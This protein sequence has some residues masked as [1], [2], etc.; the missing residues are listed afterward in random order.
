MAGLCLQQGEVAI[1]LGTSDT[2]LVSVSQYTPALEGHIFRN[3]VDLNAFMGML[4]F[5][6]GSFTRDRIRRAIGASDWESFAEILSKTPPGN[7]GNIGFYFDDNEIVPN[8]SR[9]DYRF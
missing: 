6:N 2:V 7:N 4:C 3:P 8:V 5:K 1:S 9:G